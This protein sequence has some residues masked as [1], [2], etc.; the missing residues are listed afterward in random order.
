M[1]MSSYEFETISGE[2][3]SWPGVTEKQRTRSLS[4]AISHY[5]AAPPF[6]LLPILYFFIPGYM[7]EGVFSYV[8]VFPLRCRNGLE[9]YNI[10]GFIIRW[11]KKHC[12]RHNGPRVLSP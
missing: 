1:K 3:I 8:F 2:T 11:E 12:Q 6:Q 4:K 7:C 10:A 9:H 5:Y